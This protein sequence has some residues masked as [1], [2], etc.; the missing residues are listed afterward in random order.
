MD[1]CTDTGGDHW[2]LRPTLTNAD[3]FLVFQ[4][5]HLILAFYRLLGKWAKCLDSTQGEDDH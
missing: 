3:I 1:N 4:S 5:P 2:R